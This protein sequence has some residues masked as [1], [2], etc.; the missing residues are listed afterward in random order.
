V[1]PRRNLTDHDR[2][3]DAVREIITDS[4]ARNFFGTASRWPPTPSLAAMAA[5]GEAPYRSAE[6]PTSSA[7][8]IS[9]YP[10]TATR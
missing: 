3:L 2:R 1:E 5:S 9:A 8:K 10:F 6:I 7:P 4:L